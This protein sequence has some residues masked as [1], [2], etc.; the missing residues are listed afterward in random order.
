M[1][2]PPSAGGGRTA[3]TAPPPLLAGRLPQE[4]E[5]SYQPPVIH[6]GRVLSVGDGIARV[7]GL[8]SVQVGR[9]ACRA[10]CSSRPPAPSP[11]TAAAGAQQRGMRPC[12][13]T[14]PPGPCPAPQ[15]GELVCFDSGVKGMALNLQHD[16]VG[17][18]IFGNDNA[19]HQVSHAGSRSRGARSDQRRTAPP[20]QL[21]PPARQL[22]ACTPP[23][24]P[25]HGASAA[26]CA[27]STPPP[28]LPLLAG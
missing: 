15:A 19:I 1:A 8:R 23:V 10:C 7:Y 9:R 12:H 17:V 16:H 4:W 3:S 26:H 18:V 28:P 2:W 24:L 20:Q 27:C 11:G 21:R 14:R 25:V 6:L 5:K 22:P 13:T